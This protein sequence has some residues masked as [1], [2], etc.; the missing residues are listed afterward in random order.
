LI[1]HNVLKAWIDGASRGNPGEAAIGGY[2]LSD[3]GEKLFEF[4][5][6]I[7]VATNNIA[8]YRALE[9]MLRWVE[10]STQGGDSISGLVVHS[11]SELLVRQMTGKYKIKS[12]NLKPLYEM[13][14]KLIDEL[15]FPVKFVHILRLDNREADRL[16][17]R[18]FGGTRTQNAQE[19]I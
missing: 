8:E 9:Y 3:T 5:H 13:V 7:G 2:V 11:D 4:G 10:K 16:A 15:P 18:G 1:T 12:K 19:G 6:R 14:R 17:N